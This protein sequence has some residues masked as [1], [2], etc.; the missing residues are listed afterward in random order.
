MKKLVAY[1][2]TLKSL[3][4]DFMQLRKKGKGKT[5]SRFK[6]YCKL[7]YSKKMMVEEFLNYEQALKDEK[8][9]KTFLTFREA[10]IYWKV[11]NPA[12]YAVL[13]KDKYISH[14]FL[15]R[16][17]IPTP[18]LYAYYHP[19]M[20]NSDYESLRRDLE[21]KKV[22]S[23]VI[24]PAVDGA[25]GAGVFVC[26]KIEFTPTDCILTKS[27][28]EQLSLQEFC[29]QN[30]HTS[31]LFESIVKQSEQIERIN[32]S[33][34]NTVRFMT[35]LFPDKSVKV[36][37][38]FMKI[39]R[40]GSD[41]DNA[42]GGGNVDCAVNIDTGECY[43]AL[44]FNS[45]NDI[46]DVDNHPDSGERIN[47]IKINNWD[48]I[49]RHL[50]SYQARIPQLKIIGWDVA[51]TNNGPVIIEINNYWDTTGQLFLGKGWRKEVS[52]CYLAWEKH[53]N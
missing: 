2:R 26:K 8:F 5:I 32:P 29:R 44:Q 37:A 52:E 31:W 45:F 35:A 20:G 11:L 1:L 27:N 12:R 34:V 6:K 21:S 14:L 49:K 15:E 41:V 13:A 17:G 7:R 10:C 30:S 51:L 19:E 18:E 42:G 23:C 46:K 4:K 47:G 9:S 48:D 16:A 28:E 43:N 40:A 38:T 50:C 33:S 22:T 36:F 53:Y 25:H 24:K 3:L 39:G